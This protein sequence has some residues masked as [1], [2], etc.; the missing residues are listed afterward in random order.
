MTPERLRACLAALDWTQR[1]LARLL[2]RP[3]G[4]VRQWAR[5]AVQIPP[6]VAAWLEARAR[7]AERHPPPARISRPSV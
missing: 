2:G 5:G 7:H 3:E 4:T 6:A 1:G